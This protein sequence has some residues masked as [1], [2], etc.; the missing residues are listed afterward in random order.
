MFYDGLSQ[1]SSS[2]DPGEMS[3]DTPF[4]IAPYS[5]ETQPGG[6]AREDGAVRPSEPMRMPSASSDFG[7]DNEMAESRSDMGGS[8]YGSTYTETEA[9]GSNRPVKRR[10]DSISGGSESANGREPSKQKS[11][12]GARACTNCHRL[13]MKCEGAEKGGPCLRCARSG[14]E[15]IF[16]ESHRGRKSEKRRKTAAM[17]QAF[18]KMENVLFSVIQNMNENQPNQQLAS[19]GSSTTTA[20]PMVFGPEERARNASSSSP[21]QD[22]QQRQSA[23]PDPDSFAARLQ[24]LVAGEGLDTN[25]KSMRMLVE[26]AIN[27]MQ[28]VGLMDETTRE[29]LMDS[30]DDAFLKQLLQNVMKKGFSRMPTAAQQTSFNETD[31]A[32]TNCLPDNTLNPLGL[33]AEASL[34]NWQRQRTTDKSPSVARAD[35]ETDTSSSAGPTPP[36]THT[37]RGGGA[38]AREGSAGVDKQFGLANETYFHTSMKSSASARPA[39]SESAHPPELLT[40]GIINSEEALELFRIFF[41]HCSLH[42]FLLDPE[43]HTPTLVCSRSPFLF[44]C[45]CSV[46]SKFYMQRPD[47]YVQCLRKA[48]KMAFE[49]M[50]RGSKSP[51]IVQGFLL[52]TLY[53]QPTERYEEDRTWLFAGVAIRMAQD[54]NLHRKCTLPSNPS[55]D[56]VREILNRER[57][58]YICFCVDRTL[59]AQM[60]KPYSI[61]EDWIIRHAADWCM[62]RYSRPWDLG[63]CAL[64]DLLRVQ[65]R[66]LD[67]LYSST[68][69]PSGLNLDMDYPAI[70]PSF[71]EQ[72]NETMQFWYRLGLDSMTRQW[73]PIVMD[74][75]DQGQSS[76]DAAPGA[77]G[78]A[79][80]G[81]AG[82]S[83]TS[84]RTAPDGARKGDGTQADSAMSMFE[85]MPQELMNMT[86]TGMA[87]KIRVSALLALHES[88]PPGDDADMITRSIYYIARQ[89][90]LRYN[91]AVLVLNSF[92]LQYALER[93]S[94][95][96]SVDKPLYLVRCVHAAKEIIATVKYG[97]REILRYAPDPTF[98]VVAYA[99]VF[100]LKLIR[101]TFANYINE[102]EVIALINY[103]IEVLEEAAV[104]RTHTPALYASFLRSLVQS[105]HDAPARSGAPDGDHAE[106]DTHADAARGAPHSTHMADSGTEARLARVREIMNAHSSADGASGAGAGAGAPDA[107]LGR[108]E[109]TVNPTQVNPIAA[110]L[111]ASDLHPKPGS[112]LGE[113]HAGTMGPGLPMHMDAY[114]AQDPHAHPKPAENADIPGEGLSSMLGWDAIQY[115][116]AQG[117]DVNRVLDNSFW[118]S[119]LPTG[120]GGG[121]TNTMGNTPA[122]PSRDADFFRMPPSFSMNMRTSL[123]PGATRASSPTFGMSSTF[124]L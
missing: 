81:A 33:L 98:V 46:A 5:F 70:L 2:Y 29:R 52:L 102:E 77:S 6:F 95:G 124:P 106:D 63:I 14:H 119:L 41:H 55:E 57:T 109:M 100:L 65:T 47:L 49:V 121:G 26:T 68:V 37:E 73:R 111:A 11:T 85:T 74:R 101:P 78:D 19:S 13:K 114:P 38:Q 69:T 79:T 80:R 20:S 120:Y 108:A 27:F 75:S 1:P 64:V 76:A 43:W 99:C 84:A 53:N 44:T 104:D 18:K 72:L 28:N 66:Q 7:A 58:W 96:A 103:T 48:I 9:S 97:M 86:G 105:R 3:Q 4:A 22:A 42:L 50:S 90:P 123:T 16:L 82:P 62:Q 12:R 23:S 91:Y 34:Q 94:D 60:G 87:E 116:K 93:P 21:V 45:V 115:A 122:D 113:L 117:V 40:D 51:E 10:T 71:N 31:S 88:G 39:E 89:A 112:D 15:C 54:L 8:M 110:S 25:P 107:H 30:K 36:S 59:S 35:A 67:F 56:E 92:G 61:R 83:D 17:Q 24:R 32:R 118:S